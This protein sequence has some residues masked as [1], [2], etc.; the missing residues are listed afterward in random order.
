LL[1]KIPH[2]LKRVGTLPCE[3][4]MF[5]NRCIQSSCWCFRSSCQS[6]DALT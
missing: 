3:M 6:W 1:I 4:S 5:A 2:H